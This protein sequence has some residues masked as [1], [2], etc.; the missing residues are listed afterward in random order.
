MNGSSSLS[1][2]VRLSLH[3]IACLFFLTICCYLYLCVSAVLS[4]CLSALCVRVPHSACLP[5]SRSILF[6]FCCF[7]CARV[8]FPVCGSRM[9]CQ[10]ARHGFPLSPPTKSD[11]LMHFFPPRGSGL[12]EQQYTHRQRLKQ[13]V[14]ENILMRGWCLLLFI[15]LITLAGS[16]NVI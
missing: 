8:P 4:E 1:L 7:G 6:W 14:M 9:V 3:I 13:I 12:G 10:S 5:S 2:C 16:K 15:T 11:E